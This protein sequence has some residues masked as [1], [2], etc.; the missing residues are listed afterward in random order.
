MTIPKHDGIRVPALKL[1]CENKSLK[2]KEF[3]LPLAK[4]FG[5]TEQE[6]SQEYDSG[7]GKIFYDRISWALSYMNMAGLVQKPKRGT[8]EISDIGIEQL[9]TPE[10]I[11]LFIATQIENREP[12]RRSKTDKVE[13]V[14]TNLTPQEE[15]YDSFS[16][17]QSSVYN[18][19]IDVVLSKTP[20]EFEKLVVTL[21]QHMGY[22]GEVKAAGEVTKHSNDKG[23][24]G[25]IK[26]DVLGL[27]RIYIQAKRYAKENSV[28]REEVQKFVGVLQLCVWL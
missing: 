11:N 21:L 14:I 8:Y 22:G 5:L 25:I 15:L 3:E 24:D 23:I 6:L 13:L 20:R 26:E 12:S 19:I 9:K 4:A 28:G 7:N 27:G 16:K 2:L 17:I 1:L 18:E 10:N